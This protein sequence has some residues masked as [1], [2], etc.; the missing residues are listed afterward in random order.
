[1]DG[2]RGFSAVVV[3]D[4]DATVDYLTALAATAAEVLARGRPGFR[5]GSPVL[6]QRLN[7]ARREAEDGA[8]AL[9]AAWAASGLVADVIPD[10]VRGAA[11]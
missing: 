3:R 6:R 8:R 4:L 11:G 7:E 2:E 1:M 5:A 9:A 10:W